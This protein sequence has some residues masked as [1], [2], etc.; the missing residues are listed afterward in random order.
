MLFWY[1]AKNPKLFLL[2]NSL[3]HVFASS[4]APKNQAKILYL[5]FLLSQTTLL[6]IKNLTYSTDMQG[7]TFL[8][9]ILVGSLS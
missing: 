1:Q 4:M 8:I 5:P 6:K 3:Y 2:L 7:L 9:I